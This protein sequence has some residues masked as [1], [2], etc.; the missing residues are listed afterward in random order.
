MPS[1]VQYSG[2]E[3][4]AYALPSSRY[5]KSP[6]IYYEGK[7]TYAIYKKS[8]ISFSSTDS[9][10][11]ITKETEYRPDKVSHRF[12]GAPD[13]WWKIMEMN[14]MKDIL[15]FRAGRNITLPGGSLMF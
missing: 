10:Y 6:V 8:D 4:S 3:A 1:P 14:G 9:H 5:F 12:Y 15:E 7:I 13:F 11:E 2:I